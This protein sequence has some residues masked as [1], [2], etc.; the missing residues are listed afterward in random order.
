MQW[1]NMTPNSESDTMKYVIEF[2]VRGGA[3]TENQTTNTRDQAERLARSL[4]AVFTNDP[5]ACG[6]TARDWMFSK[7]DKRMTW[8]SQ[9][10]FVAVSKLDGVMRGPASAGLW[11]KPTGPELLEGQVVSHF[12]G[13]TP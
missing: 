4:V 10:H 13:M 2:G 1:A 11:R 9:T 5:H 3:H 7:H 8:K 12:G 6:A